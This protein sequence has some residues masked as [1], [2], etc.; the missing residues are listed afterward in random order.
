MSGHHEG[1]K[2]GEKIM[3]PEIK[4]CQKKTKSWSTG[5]QMYFWYFSI[6]AFLL[7]IKGKIWE[8]SYLKPFQVPCFFWQ[9][10]IVWKWVWKAILRPNLKKYVPEYLECAREVQYSSF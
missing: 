4:P 10:Y 6:G 8:K 9:A 2:L 1:Q 7:K 5:L 3:C